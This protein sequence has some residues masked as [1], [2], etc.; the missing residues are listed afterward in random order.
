[1]SVYIAKFAL[2]HGIIE[3]ELIE[4]K[5]REPCS[6]VWVRWP[7]GLRGEKILRKTEVFVTLDEAVAAAHVLA[8]K[9][10]KSLQAQITKIE[11]T[12]LKSRF[13]IAPTRITGH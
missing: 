7:D 5:T 3:T 8:K 9:R 1:M 10:I 11:G 12:I 6:F 13:G 2:T 4:H